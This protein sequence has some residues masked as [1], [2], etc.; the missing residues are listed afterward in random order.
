MDRLILDRFVPPSLSPA[1]FTV[2]VDNMV[3]VGTD[4]QSTTDLMQKARRAME[5]AGLPTHEVSEGDADTE[6][7][8]WR[9]GRD[10]DRAAEGLAAVACA[11][12]S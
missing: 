4:A 5:A 12:L 8:G 1:S 10:G 9:L 3:V 11:T 6:V 7:L 2:Y